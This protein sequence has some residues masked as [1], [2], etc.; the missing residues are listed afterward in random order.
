MCISYLLQYCKI[1][2]IHHLDNEFA[3]E[4]NK[5]IKHKTYPAAAAIMLRPALKLFNTFTKCFGVGGA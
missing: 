2:D 5:P 3:M 4:S 1:Y